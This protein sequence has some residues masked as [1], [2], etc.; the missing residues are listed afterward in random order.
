MP[1]LTVMCPE[2]PYELNSEGV[3]RLIRSYAFAR[4]VSDNSKVSTERHILGPNITLLK[5]DWDRVPKSR[6]QIVAQTSGEFFARMST[7]AKGKWGVEYLEGLVDDRNEY[8][9]SVFEK[10]QQ[11]TA[12]TLKNMANSVETGETL[13]KASTWIRDGAAETELVLASVA[14]L[15]AATMA[16]FSGAA[17]GGYS[18]AATAGA[19]IVLGSVGKG[20]IKWQETRSILQGVAEG[21][22]E[23]Q[24]NTISLLV[25]GEFTGKVQKVVV[26]LMFGMM[27]GG[28]KYCFAASQMGLPDIAKSK[29]QS[30]A[31]YIL[32]ALKDMPSAIAKD[33]VETLTKDPNIT[34]PVTVVMKLMLKY[35]AKALSQPSAPAPPPAFGGK[36]S[37]VRT[38]LR[39]EDWAQ[40]R[41]SM[42]QTISNSLFDRARPS[43]RF[44]EES[45]LRPMGSF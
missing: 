34:I 7:G 25:K 21:F 11:S 23:L 31:H 9:S 10:Q 22:T 44:V 43:E 45:A 13:V 26:G 17:L 30:P 27:K 8:T 35:G 12:E 19:G 18:A 39:T 38:A 37:P 5:T 42:H 15:P 20:A 28:F 14:L 24:I 41:A 1:W 33:L 36:F 40:I 4:A 3:M 32:P 2:G 29:N 16:G 6:D